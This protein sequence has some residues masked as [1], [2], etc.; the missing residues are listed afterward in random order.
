MPTAFVEHAVVAVGSAM[1][2]LGRHD[3]YAMTSVLKFDSTQGTWSDCAP[4]PAARY[5]LAACAIQSDIFVFGGYCNVLD[6]DQASVFKYD[7]VADTWSTLAPMPHASSDHS[8][9]V[10]GGMVY[11]VGAGDGSEVLRFD[12][13]SGAWSTLAPT[14][15]ARNLCCT[16]VSGGYL[17][18]AGGHGISA[19]SNERYDTTTNTWTLIAEMLEA[20]RCFGSVTFGSAGPAE[21]RDLLDS[22]I[23]KAS[24]DRQ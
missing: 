9:S 5:D 4:M 22:L 23:A 11:I 12:P 2:V 17:Y 16:F 8:A 18:A 13:A 15:N 20:R 14:L 19:S 6:C 3:A 21:E 24:S 10:L 1:Y 7:T